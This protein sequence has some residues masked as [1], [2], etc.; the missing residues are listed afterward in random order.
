[1][2]WCSFWASF[3][4]PWFLGSEVS[5]KVPK[6]IYFCDRFPRLVSLCPFCSRLRFVIRRCRILFLSWIWRFWRKFFVVSCVTSFTFRIQDWFFRVTFGGWLTRRLC[7][8]SLSTILLVFSSFLPFRW[9]HLAFVFVLLFRLWSSPWL[10][11]VFLMQFSFRGKDI[12]SAFALR[13]FIIKRFTVI[14]GIFVP[15]FCGSWPVPITATLCTGW[16]SIRFSIISFLFPRWLCKRTF[17]SFM[18]WPRVMRILL[19]PPSVRSWRRFMI[20]WTPKERHS[21]KSK[22]DIIVIVAVVEY[23]ASKHPRHHLLFHSSSH[24]LVKHHKMKE[25]L[26]ST[27]KLLVRVVFNC[28]RTRHNSL[29][30]L[31]ERLKL[32]LRIWIVRIFIRMAFSRLL[33]V[34]SSYFLFTGISWKPENLITFSQ[35]HRHQ[36]LFSKAKSAKQE[37]SNGDKLFV[38][39]FSNNLRVIC[40]YY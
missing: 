18:R 5:V 8:T 9:S 25:V 27:K 7:I 23:K 21:K 16:F 30:T 17:C 26:K 14:S 13:I 4:S 31:P 19:K 6:S 24:H 29:V 37:R 15:W 40:F 32:F 1:M 39:I 28:A 20:P 10:R 22:R 2:L 35:I 34:R 38:T 36:F 3:P 11:A 12:L 33:F